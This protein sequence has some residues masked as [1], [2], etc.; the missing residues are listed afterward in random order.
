[1]EGSIVLAVGEAFHLRM[2]KDRI[3][4]AGMPSE[5]VYSIVQRK[6]NG[7]QGF[8]WNLYYSRR[9]TDIK[10]DGVD[11]VVESVSPE[12]IMFRIS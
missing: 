4:Y 2:G 7:Y 9:K 6:T 8:A 3:V 5:D 11:I 10:I 1:M 12:E